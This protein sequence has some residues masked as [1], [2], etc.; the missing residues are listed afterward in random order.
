MKY[1]QWKKNYKKNYGRN[2]SIII[3]KRKQ[4]RYKAKWQRRYTKHI[5]NF[6]DALLRLS[7]RSHRL[8]RAM[9]AFFGAD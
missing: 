1:R 8:S 6:M 9:D 3:D 4:R 2:P 7:I 5:A